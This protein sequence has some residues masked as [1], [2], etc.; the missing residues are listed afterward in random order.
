LVLTLAPTRTLDQL[1]DLLVRK[2]LEVLVSVADG[3]E[4]E[5]SLA[6]FSALRVLG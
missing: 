1:N 5:G 6:A 4:L 2:L 3:Q